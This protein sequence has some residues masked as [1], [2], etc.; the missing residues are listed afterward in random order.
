[1]RLDLASRQQA[2]GRAVAVTAYLL[3]ANPRCRDRVHRL[4]GR[5]SRPF[6][7][8][9]GHQC[10]DGDHSEPFVSVTNA[11]VTFVRTVISGLVFPPMA[12][13]AFGIDVRD[14]RLAGDLSA[15]MRRDHRDALLSFK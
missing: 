11:A 15:V 6:Q 4:P 3:V 9:A 1:M 10:P 5:S 7:G 14:L 8:E 2:H 13:R 12:D